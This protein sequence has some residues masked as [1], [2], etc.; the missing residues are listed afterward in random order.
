MTVPPCAGLALT[1]KVYCTTAKFAFTV[2]LESMV[3]THEPPPEQSP[4]QP[5]KLHPSLGT[6]VTVTW[7]PR[8]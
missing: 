4:D 5:L 7:V 6:P 2:L 3:T 1:V 8:A